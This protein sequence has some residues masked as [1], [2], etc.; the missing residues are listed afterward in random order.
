MN[1][2]TISTKYLK[3]TTEQELKVEVYYSKGGANYLAGGIIIQRGYW[4]SVQPVSQSV[5]NGLRSE[6]FTL[7]S[8][9]KYFLKETRADRR[10][11]KAEREAIKLAAAREQLLI[12]EVCLQEK[13]ELAA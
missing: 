9:L 8:G 13:L 12:K 4:L 7:G 11:G 3:T 6:S 2:R 10:G 5:S 1:Y